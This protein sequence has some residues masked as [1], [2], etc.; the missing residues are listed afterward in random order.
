M[1]SGTERLY[2]TDSHLTEFEARVTSVTESVSGWCAVTLD[3]TAFYPTGGGQPGDTGVLNSE[4]VVEC[5]A[6]EDGDVLHVIQ[7]RAPQVGALVKGRVDWERRQDHIQQH[8]GQHILSQAFVSLYGAE[9]RSFRMMDQASEI[10]VALDDPT[11]ERIDSAVELANNV[12]WED[13]PVCVRVVT[14]EEAAR[15]PLRKDSARAGELRIIEI[16]NFDL[17]PCGGTHARRTGEVGLIAVRSWERAKGLLRIEFVA[18]RRALAD[19]GRANGTARRV[20]AL[21]SVA[22]DEA[23]AG[24]ARLLEENKQLGRRIRTLEEEAARAEGE[25]FVRNADQRDD[26]LRIIA[27]TFDLRDADQLK[28]LALAIIAHPQTI[29][30]LGSR[31]RETA[32]L[33]FARSADAPGDM[34]ALMRSAC[35]MLDGRGGGRP[36]MAQGGGRH[37]ERLQEAI[38]AA[39][40]SLSIDQ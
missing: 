33:V 7:G 9:T 24:V 8:T 30:L 23:P 26:G 18:G 5:M 10:D 19:Y 14:P 39:A 38:E 36:D 13:R 16:E 3:R 12:I 29:A 11:D 6:E 27:R 15:L 31:D 2:Y 32:R 37:V 34:S 25:E 17:S 40:A 1:S 22:R 20:A 35:E 4:P 21:F 28:H